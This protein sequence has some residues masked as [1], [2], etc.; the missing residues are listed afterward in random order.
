MSKRFILSEPKFNQVAVNPQVWPGAVRVSYVIKRRKK[1]I[2]YL[3]MTKHSVTAW[4]LFNIDLIWD[5]S[6]VEVVLILLVEN[7]RGLYFP[8]K[9]SKFEKNIYSQKKICAIV[10]C[11]KCRTSC[12][13][14]C[15]QHAADVQLII[16]KAHCK[17]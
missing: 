9:V 1:N 8:V 10:I 11:Y 12:T 3:K 17:S 7:N 2:C 15:K 6:V 4:H 13:L 14:T 5:Y 16:M